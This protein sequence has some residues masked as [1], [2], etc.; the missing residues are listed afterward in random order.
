MSTF[1]LRVDNAMRIEVENVDANGC[2]HVQARRTS[3]FGNDPT[4]I[5]L[6]DGECVAA[7]YRVVKDRGTFEMHHCDP[8]ISKFEVLID[9]MSLAR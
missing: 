1:D 2:V 5:L 8:S 7:I 3:S 9:Q 6:G 4:L